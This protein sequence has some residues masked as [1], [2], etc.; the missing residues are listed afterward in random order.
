LIK[1]LQSLYAAIKELAAMDFKTVVFDTIDVVEHLVTQDVVK[2]NGWK[3]LETPGY[4]KGPTMAAE[5]FQIFMRGTDVLRSSGKNVILIG[6]SQITRFED[7]TGDGYDQI[8]I[9]ANKRIASNILAAMD[10]VLFADI[11]IEKQKSS[12]RKTKAT[13]SG[14]RILRCTPGG[15][16][17]AKNRFNLEPEETMTPQLWSKFV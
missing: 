7:P 11:V 3:S 4:G 10:A 15:A 5:A 9:K 2:T 12:D 16:Y 1:D 8:S 13:S 14:E 17:V 6:H